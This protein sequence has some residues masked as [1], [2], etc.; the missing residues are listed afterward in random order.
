MKLNWLRQ[1]RREAELDEE[2][3][4][5]LDQAI[6]D[7]I[8][9]GETP[10]DARAQALREFGNV[11]LVRETTREVWGWSWLEGVEKDLRF[12]LRMLWKNPGFS[13][14]AVFT[15][16]LGIGA[17]SVIYALVDQLMLHNVTAHE[18]ERLV[19]FSHG[20]WS[21]YPN[22]QDLRKSGVF[23]D[24]ASAPHCYPEPRWSVG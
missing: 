13:L 23:A 15:L 9:R 5:H 17:T 11:T 8:E 18:P 19:S 14:I 21:S 7:R 6:R 1:N 4:G 10:E 24:L 22:F 2:I 12:G 16:A 3:R 20:P